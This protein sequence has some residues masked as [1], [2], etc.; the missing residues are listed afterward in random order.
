MQKYNESGRSMVE[1]LAVLAIAGVITIGGLTGFRSVIEK[2]K[3]NEI[4]EA[5]AEIST[6]AMRNNMDVSKEKAKQILGN[7]MPN[8]I[9]FLTGWRPDGN[10]V[11]KFKKEC[12][13][14]MGLVEN[15]FPKCRWEPAGMGGRY[16]PRRQLEG[17]RCCDDNT[18]KDA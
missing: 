8:C 14:I 11:V 4:V 12:E 17:N 5:I 7:D 18:C 2:K 13:D 9:E 6:Y 1:M 10:V 16:Y 15:N 3:A